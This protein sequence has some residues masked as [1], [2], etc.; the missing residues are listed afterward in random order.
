MREDSLKM[1]D[2]ELWA[3][4]GSMAIFTTPVAAHLVSYAQVGAGETLL[5]VGTGTG[6][7]AI[8]A[9]RA[10]AQVSAI[11]L[12][13]QLLDEARSNAKIAGH[14]HIAWTEGTAEHLPYEDK[15]FDVV[16]SQFGHMFAPHPDEVIAEM[17]RVLKPGGRIAFATWP[18][19][20]LVGQ[21]FALIG[22]HGPELPPS[23]S[24]PGRWGDQT[25]IAERLGTHFDDPSF[26]RGT[27]RLPALSL[28]H[29]RH[30]IEHSIGPMQKLIAASSADPLKLSALRAA[31]DAMVEPYYAE[32]LVHQHYLLTR[33]QVR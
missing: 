3:S 32:N 30:F 18:P 13:P 26:E 17:H 23:I 14:E 11:D 4:F 9:A 5:D 12:T 25:F 10:G 19:D 15:S 7:V 31:F 24:P 22:S 21:M 33:A 1:P 20:R 29:Y 27:M 16:L 28:A 6:V 2:R 8:T